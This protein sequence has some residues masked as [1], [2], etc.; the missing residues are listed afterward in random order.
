[1]RP[2][3]DHRCF[4]MLLFLSASDRFCAVSGSKR[5]EKETIE[6]TVVG[7][8]LDKFLDRAFTQFPLLFSSR[9]LCSD[10]D[11]EIAFEATPTSTLATFFRDEEAI[12]TLL[13][14]N[15]RGRVARIESNREGGNYK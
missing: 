3:S 11:N 5:T 15:N 13:A 9:N 8:A 2:A 14:S 1:M 6:F 4:S 7:I 10:S 12:E